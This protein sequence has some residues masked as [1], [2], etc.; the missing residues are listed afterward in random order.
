MHLWLLTLR[1]TFQGN[2][3][4]KL[5]STLLM[6]AVPSLSDKIPM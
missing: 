6:A 3:S 4:E 2:Y 1:E 5:L